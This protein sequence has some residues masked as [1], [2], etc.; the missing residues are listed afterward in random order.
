MG[1]VKSTL[2]CQKFWNIRVGHRTQ[3]KRAGR[4]GGLLGS[5][6]SLPAPSTPGPCELLGSPLGDWGSSEGSGLGRLGTQFPFT[7][8]G[9]NTSPH[10][11]ASGAP[12]GDPTVP[13]RLA[14]PPAGPCP[15]FPRGRAARPG[16]GAPLARPRGPGP[17][18]NARPG[19]AS[20]TR[21][22]RGFLPAGRRV[23]PPPGPPLRPPPSARAGLFPSTGRIPSS[24]S[25][26]GRP[27]DETCPA[28][29]ANRAHLPPPG[30][31][32]LL[33]QPDKRTER[34]LTRTATQKNKTTKQNSDPQLP[35][36]NF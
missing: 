33:P 23:T 14:P 11:P 2:N 1:M 28:R 21:R 25:S 19:S 16:S 20:A 4:G 18:P 3:K 24:T 12:S 8:F 32:A 35:G 17:P 15:G 26:L 30:A 31:R 5:Q 6:F 29:S 10:P 34:K 9:E 13:L 36:F 27:S 22:S 7:D